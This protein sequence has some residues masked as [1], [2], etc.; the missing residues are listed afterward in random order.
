MPNKN[1]HLFDKVITMGT[2]AYINTPARIRFIYWPVA[3]LPGLIRYFLAD[4][5]IL[6]GLEVKNRNKMAIRYTGMEQNKNYL[7]HLAYGESCNEIYVG[8]KWLWQNFKKTKGNQFDLTVTEIPSFLQGILNR[9]GRFLVPCWISSE[10][11]ISE[12]VNDIVAKNDSLKNECR[13]IRKY[14]LS[15]TVT[16]SMADLEEFYRNMYLPYMKVRYDK[17]SFTEDYSGLKNCM[18]NGF[19]IF[20]KN[21]EQVIAGNLVNLE[22][23]IPILRVMGVK[24]GNFNYLKMGAA[25]ATYFFTIQLLQQKG[26]RRIHLGSTRAFLNDGVLQYKKSWGMRFLKAKT[27]LFLVEPISK[28]SGVNDFLLNNPF[29]CLKNN[30]LYGTIFEKEDSTFHN[31]PESIQ[32]KFFVNGM[33]DVFIRKIF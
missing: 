11:D 14:N 16:N 17:E 32:K 7:A 30:N 25:S 33:S 27:S 22:N 29:V 26:Y 31:K 6:T 18:R 21:G 28:M 8:K 5:W 24:D 23:N 19:L 4:Q 3:Y 2:K 12:S 13:K 10:I 15:Y 9:K 1:Y 20:I